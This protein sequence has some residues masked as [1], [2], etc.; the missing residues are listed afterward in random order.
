M[1]PADACMQEFGRKGSICCGPSCVWNP[2]IAAN[3]RMQVVSA[4]AANGPQQA[5]ASIHQYALNIKK[6]ST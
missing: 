1:I 4:R 2:F 6:S 3:F 5:V